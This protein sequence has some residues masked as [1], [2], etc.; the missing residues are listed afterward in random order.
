MDQKKKA[1]LAQAETNLKL[2]MQSLE[3]L[4]E[5]LIPFGTQAS[6]VRR[7]MDTEYRI[8]G[9]VIAHDASRG[10]LEIR[11]KSRTGALHTAS[12]SDFSG[13]RIED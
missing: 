8:H 11:I 4:A 9:T 6:F 3:E 13:F 2:A 1:R 12:L 7:R 10:Y 5:Q